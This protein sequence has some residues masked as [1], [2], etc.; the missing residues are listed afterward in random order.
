MV[1]GWLLTYR[2]DSMYLKT[3]QMF[4]AFQLYMC[5]QSSFCQIS[6]AFVGLSMCQRK[7]M[8]VGSANA[9]LDCYYLPYY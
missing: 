6:V 5:F 3:N 8:C 7:I 4:F 9:L 1:E 2:T